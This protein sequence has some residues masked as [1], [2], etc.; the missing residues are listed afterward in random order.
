[1]SKNKA[2]KVIV[3]LSL[4]ALVLT[5]A[6]FAQAGARGRGRTTSYTL[7][8]NSNVRGAQVQIDGEN[9]GSTPVS[10]TLSR[11]Q[12][13]LEVRADGYR[14]YTERISINGDTTINADL[15]AINYTLSVSA[16][17]N[18]AE[19]VVEGEGEGRGSLRIAVQPGE[20]RIRAS[21]DGYRSWSRTV[22][23]NSDTT[24]RAELDP[25]TYSLNIDPDLGNAQIVVEGVGQGRGS[26][27]FSV[28][29]G[30][31]T[32]RITAP[33]YDDYTTRVNIRGN[34][35]IRPRLTPSTVTVRVEIP[36][37]MLA[38]GNRNPKEADSDR[39][40]EFTVF[41]DGNEQSGSTFQ[42]RP[43]RHDFRIVSGG[44]SANGS[45]VLNPGQTYV[46][47]PSLTLSLEQ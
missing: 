3:A 46:L 18:N 44:W 31:Y 4:M 39:S 1:M 24:V 35:T 43:G 41:I 9:R 42:V 22:N 47:K 6:V 12:Y 33:G 2:F 28:R 15:E 16:N 20:Y 7:T 13:D 32:V 23:V 27:N 8:I 38:G 11:G 45:F 25:I 30:T 14:T 40:G 5:S 34:Q 10:V 21:A 36:E 17:V 26:A 19:I 29:P 37:S